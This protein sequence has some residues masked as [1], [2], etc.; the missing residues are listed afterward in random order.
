MERVSGVI[1]FKDFIVLTKWIIGLELKLSP[2]VFIQYTLAQILIT[3]SPIAVS[4]FAAQI[5]N[6]LVQSQINFVHDKSHIIYLVI[7]LFISY[8]L[9]S[10]GR[11]FNSYAALRIQYS[12]D[13]N[14][15]PLYIQRAAEID[16]QY[17]ES[18]DFNVFTQKTSEAMNWRAINFIK[19]FSE[20]LASFIGLLFLIGIFFTLNILLIFLILIPIF[21]K[22]FINKKFGADL[23][24]FWDSHTD[25]K[26]HSYYAQHALENK[27]VLREAKIYGFA[28]FITDKFVNSQKEFV[29][30]QSK[31]INKKYLAISG[32]SLINDIIFISI[33][34][35]LIVQVLLNAL[36][37]GDYTFY[38]SNLSTA[39]RTFNTLESSISTMYESALYIQDLQKYFELPRL[40]PISKNPVK[41]NRESPIIEFKDVS[42]KYP[43]SDK[44]ILKNISFIIHANEKIAIVGSNGAGKTTLIK[45]LARF[46]DV[47][48]GEILIN[49]TNIQNIDLNQ[50]YKLWGILFQS[51]AKMWFKVKEN[52]AIG[53]IEDMDDITLIQDAAIRADAQQFINELPNKYDNYL[54]NDIK[55][56]VDLSGGQWQK[57]GIARS[58]FASPKLIVL[59][60]P[61][62]ALDALAEAEVFGQINHLS[63]NA[64]VI[65]VS[66]RFSTVR[67]AQKIIVLDH[68][69]LIEMGSHDELIIKDGKYHKMFTTQ[70]QGYA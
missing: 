31:K 38:I 26:V 34:I 59:D 40:I 22:F 37:V 13:L 62:S 63:Q 36:K 14:A 45:L 55:D 6:T 11:N 28:G 46:Y 15:W 27:D 70:A 16:F 9:D 41:L 25:V 35:Y 65:I 69:T 18:P 10:F 1:K 49:S 7:G 50:Y 43:N 52:I 3:I 53:N 57:I 32:A 30:D 54:T 17:V 51:F 23:Y 66:H 8:S 60:E 58:M 4:F 29:K 20:L 21:I 5:V 2:T 12:W 61:T 39:S 67:Q 33:N 24:A 42:F 44:Y 64:T 68:G 56:G 47:T 48:E 19:T